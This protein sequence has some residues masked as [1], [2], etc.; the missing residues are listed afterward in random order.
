[1]GPPWVD[2]ARGGRLKI[3]AGQNDGLLEEYR[4]YHR[5]E[6]GRVVSQNDDALSALRYGVMMLRHART[7]GWK[8]N[9][10]RQIDYPNL[11]IEKLVHALYALAT[12]A[13]DVQKRLGTAALCFCPARPEDIPYEDLRRTFAGIKDDLAFEPAKGSEGSIAATLQITD[14]EDVR[15]IARRIVTLYFDSDDRLK[16]D[17][18]D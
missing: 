9:F 16:R 5:D 8:A 3:F 11:G 12:G 2:R 6:D 13:G 18:R 1:M 17:W 7:S 4:L 10:H 14:D 15:A